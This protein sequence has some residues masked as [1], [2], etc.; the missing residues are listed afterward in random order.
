MPASQVIQTAQQSQVVTKGQQQ[1][2]RG[3][4]VSFVV[5]DNQQAGPSRPLTFTLTPMKQFNPLSVV[6]AP[7]AE[8]HDSMSGLSR[9]FWNLPSS[10]FGNIL[11]VLS[12]QQI[13][14]PQLFSPDTQT[15]AAS[16]QTTTAQQQQ[17][18][19]VEPLYLPP[20]NLF[21]NHSCQTFKGPF[22][23]HP[24]LPKTINSFCLKKSQNKHYTDPPNEK[25]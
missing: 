2:S 10:F 7:G 13:G 17:T 4:S 12:Y 19:A 20:I 18:A 8:S 23:D 6:S 16:P 1:Q 5:A 22:Q 15:Q 9:F 24:N 11:S 14:T 21:Q 25:K 3:Q